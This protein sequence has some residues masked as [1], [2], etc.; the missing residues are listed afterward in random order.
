MTVWSAQGRGCALAGTLVRVKALGGHSW[1]SGGRRRSVC[2]RA[3]FR[4]A[5]VVLHVPP[6]LATH[7]NPLPRP[8]PLY[9]AT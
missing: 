3:S 4:R 8:H 1:G 6:D 7:L 9:I 5:T 2:K